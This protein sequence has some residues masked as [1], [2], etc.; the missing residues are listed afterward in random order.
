MTTSKE[1]DRICQLAGELILS[2]GNIEIYWYLIFTQILAETKRETVDAIYNYLESSALKRGLIIA[3]AETVYTPH[4]KTKKRNPKLRKIGQLAARTNDLK[5]F[6]NAIAHAELTVHA[7]TRD[8]GF[9]ISPGLDRRK[10]NRFA[11]KSVIKELES[12]VKDVERLTLDLRDFSNSIMPYESRLLPPEMIEA[13]HKQGLQ[14]PSWA[15]P[16]PS[17]KSDDPK[18]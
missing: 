3:V 1:L 4:P 8:G 15:I 9:G 2:W 7:G 12:V 14:V 5:G 17:P 10:P 11:G 13:L 16:S 6:R 18:T